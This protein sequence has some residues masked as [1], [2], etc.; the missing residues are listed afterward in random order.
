MRECSRKRP[1]TLIT[2]MLGLQSGHAGSQATEAADDQIDRHAGLGGG[3]ER[4]DDVAILQ[5][6]HFGDDMSRPTLLVY[7]DLALDHFQEPLLHVDRCDQQFGEVGL[8]RQAGQVVKQLDHIVCDFRIAGQQP[9]V[10][11]ELGGLR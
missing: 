10:S 5:L 1:M 9:E 7:L 3:V 2:R 6:V 4:F 8:E 11:V